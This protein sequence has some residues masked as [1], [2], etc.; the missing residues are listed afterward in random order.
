MLKALDVLLSDQVGCAVALLTVRRCLLSKTRGREST[1][2]EVSG[3][4]CSR[5]YWAGRTILPRKENGLWSF[6]RRYCGIIGVCSNG[7][8][9]N[10]VRSLG[11]GR[12][13]DPWGFP[14]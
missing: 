5:K 8:S 4:K 7:L 2:Q 14:A 12:A 6:F 3:R 11:N 9:F 1:L 10:A 13:E